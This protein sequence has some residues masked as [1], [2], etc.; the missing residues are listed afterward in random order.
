MPTTSRVISCSRGA[1]G[2]KCKTR[3]PTKSVKYTISPSKWP[4]STKCCV[5][6]ASYFYLTVT[7]HCY[8]PTSTTTSFQTTT[9][10]STQTIKWTMLLTQKY[11]PGLQAVLVRF[12]S[13][14]H[15]QWRGKVLRIQKSESVNQNPGSDN[16]GVSDSHDIQ[17]RHKMKSM[18][19]IM[20][21]FQLE[22][23]I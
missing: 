18:K 4:T 2:R 13:S 7:Q 23:R 16:I 17:H 10:A 1:G 20:A 3:P 8:S 5:H 11:Q 12:T 21:E 6:Q 15:L 14:R 9:S 22:S 19:L